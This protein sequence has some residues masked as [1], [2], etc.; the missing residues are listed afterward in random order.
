VLFEKAFGIWDAKLPKE[1]PDI[2]RVKESIE[3]CKGKLD[4]VNS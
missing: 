2:A 1:H 4:I 3:R